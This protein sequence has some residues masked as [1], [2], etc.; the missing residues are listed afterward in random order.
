MYLELIRRF[1]EPTETA[2]NRYRWRVGEYIFS[3][4]YAADNPIAQ[5]SVMDGK[6]KSCGGGSGDIAFLTEVYERVK[7]RANQQ[8]HKEGN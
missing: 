7:R 6:G 5:F 2:E 3:V 4:G 8:T 1:G